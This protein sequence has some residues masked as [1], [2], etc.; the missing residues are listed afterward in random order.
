VIS[1][2]YSIHVFI[3]GAGASGNLVQGNLIGTDATGTTALSLQSGE[4]IALSFGASDNTIGGTSPAARNLISGNAIGIS[5]GTDSN[6]VEGNF[7]GTDITGTKAIG[8]VAGVAV[9][10]ASGN[11]VGGATAGPGNLISGNIGLG[12][13]VVNATGTV[14]QGNLV[15]TD[16][17]GTHDLGN[18]QNGIQVQSASDNTI[19]GTAPTASNTIAFNGEDGVA[20]LASGT[21]NAV[22]G[23]SIFSNDLLGI[24]LQGAFDDPGVVTP[25]DSGDSDTGPNDFQNFPVLA[26]VTGG[27]TTTVS[28]SLNSTPGA[29]FTLDFYTSGSCDPSSHGE[30]TTY[31]GSASVSTNSGGDATFSHALGSALTGGFL[32]TTATDAAGNTSEFSKCLS[33]SLPA[34]DLSLTK[35]DSP[36]PVQVGAKLTYQLNVSNAGPDDATGVALTDSLPAG[37]TLVSA[38]PSQG[39]CTGTATVTCD[40]G[41]MAKGAGAGVTIV[42]TPTAAGTIT[43]TASVAS[44]VG[45]PNTANNAAQATT[46]VTSATAD[47]SV[48][49]SDAPDPAVPGGD[50]TYTVGVQNHGPGSAATVSVKDPLP[51]ATTFQSVNVSPGWACTS[52]P[53]GGTGIVTCSKASVGAQEAATFTI[54]VSLDASAAAPLT[55]TA[56]VTSPTT[57]PTPGNNSAS[58]TTALEAAGSDLSVHLSASPHPVGAGKKLTYTLAVQDH[59]PEA[60]QNVVMVDHLPAMTRFWSIQARGWSCT[61]P[62]VGHRGRIRCTKGSLAPGAVSTIELVV[63]VGSRAAGALITDTANV[64]SDLADPKGANNSDS[65]RTR[66]RHPGPGGK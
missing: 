36:D 53:V 61:H 37:V 47:L 4:G 22:R 31:V 30:G 60:A 15:G 9:S 51:G 1:S 29:A 10:G 54:Q 28:G 55:D 52:P 16:V 23:N 21:G 19:G 2:S 56:T 63:R 41:S 13:W 66:V 17:T 25:N 49:L 43:N 65:A 6:V 64:H 34:A 20:I 5:I 35:S 45:D 42:V 46:T 48:S 62:Q 14:V 3:H 7:I 38:T 50:L 27:N 32:T 58:A 12:L 44:S 18:G 40:L 39:S 57:D 11:A 8:N 59:G 26:S 33:F 24:D